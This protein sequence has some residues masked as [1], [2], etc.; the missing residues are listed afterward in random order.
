MSSAQILVVGSAGFVGS[1]V[2]SRLGSTYELVLAQRT[3]SSRAGRQPPS[4]GKVVEVDLEDTG[5]ARELVETLRPVAVVNCAAAVDFSPLSS[6]AKL[7][8]VNSLLPSVLSQACSKVGAHLVHLSGSIVHGSRSA[9]AGV[10]D[11][12]IP[13]SPYGETKL[14]GDQM[15]LAS[16]ADASVLRLPG[17][18]GLDGPEHLGLNR[19]LSSARDGK[20]VRLFG[21]DTE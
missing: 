21:L 18:F 16:G 1:V 3:L 11:V 6:I 4:T 20:P 19:A 9:S 17:V 14:L 10:A 5:A 13:D 2:A 15:V 8:T 12:P 7:W